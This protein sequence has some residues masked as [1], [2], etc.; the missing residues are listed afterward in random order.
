MKVKKITQIISFYFIFILAIA[1]FLMLFFNGKKVSYHK[2]GNINLTTNYFY[3]V[4]H[5]KGSS[6]SLYGDE[7]CTYKYNKGKLEGQY[8]CKNIKTEMVTHESFFKSNKKSGYACD[9]HDNGN[10]KSKMYEFGYLW[11]ETFIPS[12]DYSHKMYDIVF[13][14]S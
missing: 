8:I 2:N 14:V 6:L 10:L 7:L 1:V 9:Y 3:G 13:L 11:A 5:G 4:K 12:I